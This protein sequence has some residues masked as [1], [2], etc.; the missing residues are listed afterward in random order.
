LR[1]FD[2]VRAAMQH[3]KKIGDKKMK[4]FRFWQLKLNCFLS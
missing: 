4:F 2:V 3:D 1:K